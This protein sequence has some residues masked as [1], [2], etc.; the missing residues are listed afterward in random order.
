MTDSYILDWLESQSESISVSHIRNGISGD[1]SSI[2]FQKGNRI[3][4]FT[5]A[6]QH[7]YGKNLR[8]AIHKAINKSQING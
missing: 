1:Q 8:D 2:E 7:V 6:S 5:I 3:L 4:L